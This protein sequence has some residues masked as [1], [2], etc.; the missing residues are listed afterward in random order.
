MADGSAAFTMLRIRPK[1]GGTTPSLNNAFPRG[2]PVDGEGECDAEFFSAKGWDLRNR[3]ELI[4]ST[5]SC[6]DDKVV[7]PYRVYEGTAKPH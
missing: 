5:T 2:T 3:V 1:S 4:E 7:G 6:R